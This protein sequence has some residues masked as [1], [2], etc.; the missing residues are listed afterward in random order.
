M[1]PLDRSY[2]WG[3]SPMTAGP[4]GKP[5]YHESGFAAYLLRDARQMPRPAGGSGGTGPGDRRSD[6]ATALDGGVEHDREQPD[7]HDRHERGGV[8]A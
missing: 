2:G 1:D 4:A 5:R 6:G 7:Q 3:A 8:V